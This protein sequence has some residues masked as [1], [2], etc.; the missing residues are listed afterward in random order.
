MILKDVCLNIKRISPKAI[1][2][3]VTNP[4]DLMT[5]FALKITG[6]SPDKLFGMGVSLDAARFANIISKQ[7]NIPVTQI[8]PCVVGSHGEGM[9][10]LARFTKINGQGLEKLLKPQ[11]ITDL[12]SS[13]ILRGAEIVSLLGSGSAFFA[14][15]AAIAE[16]VKSVA[17][18]QKRTIG[19][20]AYLNGEYG[21]NDIC[22]GVPGIIGRNGIEKVVELELNRQERELLNNCAEKMRTL[23]ET[24]PY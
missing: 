7:L 21:L 17:Q 5:Y 22:L 23:I 20:C 16:L 9:L 11:E 14:P 2:I 3:I 10:P 8:E 15:S 6:F 4:L 19:I 18:D 12:I 24:L 1:V 13:T